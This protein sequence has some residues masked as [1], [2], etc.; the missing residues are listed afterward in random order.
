MND[1]DKRELDELN[2]MIMMVRAKAAHD[3]VDAAEAALKAA[4]NAARLADLETRL[5]QLNNRLM[6]EAKNG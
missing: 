4:Q 1:A 6:K 2:T 3:A 5:H